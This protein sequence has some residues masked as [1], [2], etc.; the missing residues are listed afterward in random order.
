M[1]SYAAWEARLFLAGSKV[2]AQE[3]ARDPYFFALIAW[4]KA[5][6]GPSS[7]FFVADGLCKPEYLDWPRERLQH[8]RRRAI[9]EGW[10]VQIRKP[11]RGVAALYRWGATAQGLRNSVRYPQ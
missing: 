3:L 10:I 7:E 8:A 2:Q 9:V 6:N 1:P 5:E 11:A 4:L